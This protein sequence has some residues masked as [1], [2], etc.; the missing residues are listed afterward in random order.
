MHNSIDFPSPCEIEGDLIMAGGDLSPETLLAA[1]RKGI[2]P[3]FSQGEPILWWSLDPRFVLFP[4]DLHVSKSLMRRIQKRDLELTVDHAFSQ[5]IQGCNK[6]DRAGQDGTWITRD[7]AAAYCRLHD[8]GYAHS[9]EAWKDGRLVGGLYGVALGG[10]FY[11]ESMFFV[12]RD[13]SKITFTA[14]V[15]T[16][17]DA[18]FGLIDCQQKTRHLASFGAVSIAR[19]TFLDMLQRELKK[20]TKAGTWAE[21]FPAFPCSTLWNR[22]LG[23]DGP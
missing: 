21:I 14:L 10:C 15:G 8:L 18:D 1:Y 7:M 9:V 6:M 22:L 3:W 17:I 12:E 11:G 4:T 2:F 19:E 23:R 5:V 20:E 16:L 13:A